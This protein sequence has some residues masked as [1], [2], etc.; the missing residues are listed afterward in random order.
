MGDL[1]GIRRLLTTVVRP[2]QITGEYVFWALQE[3]KTDYGSPSRFGVPRFNRPPR[4]SI[5]LLAGGSWLRFHGAAL[6]SHTIP[7]IRHIAIKAVG[8][9]AANNTPRSA[10]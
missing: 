7:R 5:D 10:T 1:Y 3:L 9:Q 8:M 2:C 6:S 4:K